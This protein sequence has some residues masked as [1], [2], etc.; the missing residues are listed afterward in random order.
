MTGK[1]LGILLVTIGLATAAALL[2]GPR[3][4]G[5]GPAPQTTEPARLHQQTDGGVSPTDAAQP[6]QD[7][8]ETARKP[9]APAPAQTME[10]SGDL[11]TAEIPK[12]PEDLTLLEMDTD[13]AYARQDELFYNEEIMAIEAE[14]E[15][16][17]TTFEVDDE[18]LEEQDSAAY[19][20]DQSLEVEP[21]SDEELALD[22][23]LS[24]ESEAVILEEDV[25][26]P[27]D[28]FA[29]DGPN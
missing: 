10:P 27:E 17:A 18:L 3:L 7:R 1:A 25:L 24:W 9:A 2:Y 28:A 4:Y 29:S 13:D 26:L 12:L 14:Y 8:P 6:A 11:T 15:M 21:R 23:E 19:A 5:P 16:D 20:D 22:E